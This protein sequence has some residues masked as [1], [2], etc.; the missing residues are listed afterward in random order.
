MANSKASAPVSGGG[1]QGSAGVKFWEALGAGTPASPFIGCD[2]QERGAA[3]RPLRSQEACDFIQTLPCL[4]PRLTRRLRGAGLHRSIQLQA[5]LP[6]SPAQGSL[7][8]SW[9][10]AGVGGLSLQPTGGAGF[11]AAGDEVSSSVAKYLSLRKCWGCGH[12]QAWGRRV[13]GRQL[14]GVGRGEWASS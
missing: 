10:E 14:A 1:P 7:L 4:H 5:C 12:C 8:G 13:W 2:E 3:L 6:Q 9:G 11:Q